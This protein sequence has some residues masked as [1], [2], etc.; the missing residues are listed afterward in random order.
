MKK[1]SHILVAFALAVLTFAGARPVQ[2]APAGAGNLVKCPD[3]SAVYYL[4]QDGNRYVFQNEPTFFSWYQNYNEVKIISCADLATLR[5]A[6]VVHYQPGTRLVKI[7]SVPTVYIVQTDDV[8]RPLPSE[9]EAIALFGSDWADRVDDLSE[10]FF[11]QYEVGEELAEGELPEGTIL[12]DDNGDLFVFEDIDDDQEPEAVEIDELLDDDLLLDFALDLEEIEA[13]LGIEL[14]LVR[15]ETLLS[16]LIDHL[17][18]LLEERVFVPADEEVEVPELDEL[19]EAEDNDEDDLPDEFDEDDDNDGLDDDDDE[20]PFDHD[21]DGVDDDEDDDD[22]EDGL[23]DDDDEDPLDHDND[24]LED[25]EDIDDDEDD[26]D[27]DEDPLDHDNDGLDD[28][29]DMDDDDDGIEDAEDVDDDENEMEEEV[30]NNDGDDLSDEVDQDDDDDDIP[31]DEDEDPLDH[32]NDGLDD[33]VDDDDGV[34][35]S[36]V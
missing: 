6:G 19:D 1:F 34:D 31:D 8:L 10:A 24:G 35:G 5:L 14:D 7:P 9:E 20:D 29:E 27:E 15:L 23:D 32:D 33:D 12:E 22:D 2:A 18:A 25:D 17:R 26:I 11:P 36:G 16:E 13:E 4:A 28:A 3:F 30:E 21:N